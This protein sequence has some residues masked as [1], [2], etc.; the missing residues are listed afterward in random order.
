MKNYLL[1]AAAVGALV[2]AGVSNAGPAAAQKAKDTLRLVTIDPFN[3]V[4]A[5][6]TGGNE[7]AFL[8]RELYGRIVVFDEYNGKFIPELAKSFTRVNPTTIDFEF[9][10]DLTFHSGNKFSVDDVYYTLAWAIDP[11]VKLRNKER[12]SW[13]DR[14]EKLG[15][16]KLRL[17]GKEHFAADIFTIAYRFY[18]LDSKIH[19]AMANKADYGRV[20]PSATGLYKIMSVDENQGVKLERSNVNAGKFAHRRAPIKYINTV[21]LPDRQT[22][23][24]QL[25]TGGVDMVREIS[26]EMAE[27]LKGDPNVAAT[28]M[29]SKQLAYINFDVLGRSGN[30]VFKDL[31]VRQ[32]FIKAIPRDQ[33]VK[34]YIAGAEVAETPKAICFEKADACAPTTT[35]LSYDPAGARKLLTEAGYPNGIDFEISVYAPYRAV[36]EAMSGELRKVG[37]RATVQPMTLSVFTKKREAGEMTALLQAYNTFAQPTMDNILNHFFEGGRDYVNDPII[38]AATKAGYGET[39]LVKRTAIYRT[40]IDRVNEMAYVYPFSE[41]PTVYAHSKDVKIEPNQFS[42]S[43]VRLGDFFWK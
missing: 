35:P 30:A 15:P 6:Y 37:I 43:E 19:G 5:Y 26:S 12:Y 27:Q 32:A 31:R 34:T 18:I 39:D 29:L 41:Q 2:L 25:I 3:S 1:S 40:A 7:V 11:N 42:L 22:Q 4:D 33:I 28:P 10:D 8:A 20:N 21:P 17:V 14:V 9:R 13:V 36:A 23:M 38:A 24:A 16:N